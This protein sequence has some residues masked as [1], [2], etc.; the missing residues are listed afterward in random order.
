MHFPAVATGFRLLAK[1]F[2][3]SS[4]PSSSVCRVSSVAS[5][6]SIVDVVMKSVEAAEEVTKNPVE[7]V[8][9][10][11]ERKVVGV[12]E[13]TVDLEKNTAETVAMT[14]SMKSTRATFE[15]QSR[16]DSSK[17]QIECAPNGGVLQARVKKDLELVTAKHPIP[18]CMAQRV[19]RGEADELMDKIL[20]MFKELD[21]MK[22]FRLQ[23]RVPAFDEDLG[24]G[25]QVEDDPPLDTWVDAAKEAE[26][27]LDIARCEMT[28]EDV[29][30]LLTR[31]YIELNRFVVMHARNKEE[32]KRMALEVSTRIKEYAEVLLE[33]ECEIRLA[34][35]RARVK[36]VVAKRFTPSDVQYLASLTPG[37]SHVP[38][39]DGSCVS[40]YLPHRVAET[41]EVEPVPEL[42]RS[43]GSRC[44]TPS[45]VP[46]TPRAS[47]AELQ[48]EPGIIIIS[49]ETRKEVMPAKSRKTHDPTVSKK[50]PVRKATKVAGGKPAWRC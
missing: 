30:D 9:N 34:V 50:M 11:V 43:E 18:R 32:R 17:I 31:L 21:E 49:E 41:S 19:E 16:T 13:R 28:V 24:D 29:D 2:V 12:A 33:S 45:E 26:I 23:L 27:A 42:A 10:G 37:S 40:S 36:S 46:S 44:S 47:T 4:V 7:A 6:N 14:E 5:A 15:T 35:E 38:S 22:K 3:R 8:S 48:E 20:K 39:C 1:C 25:V